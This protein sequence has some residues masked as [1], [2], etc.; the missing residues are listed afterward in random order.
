MEDINAIIW[1]LGQGRRTQTSLSSPAPGLAE[2]V[3]K[4]QWV[5][6]GE[7]AYCYVFPS[8]R[9]AIVIDYA[10]AEES[11]QE[12]LFR[13]LVEEG[14][15]SPVEWAAIAAPTACPSVNVCRSIVR[16]RDRAA[17]LRWTCRVIGKKALEAIRARQP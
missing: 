14:D 5:G 3:A 1:L 15:R 13:R 9:A 16:R 12:A 11:P 2:L 4:E 10:A 17:F 8:E 6:R 7:T